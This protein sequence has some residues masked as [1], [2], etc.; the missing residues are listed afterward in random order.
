MT[1]PGAEPTRA[2]GAMWDIC[3]LSAETIEHPGNAQLP[4]NWPVTVSRT[5][6]NLPDANVTGT[7]MLSAEAE[8]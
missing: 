6:R 4:L 7:W 1:P 3:M 8:Q 2:A 5:R